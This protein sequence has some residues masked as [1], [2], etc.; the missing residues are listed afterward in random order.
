MPE[1]RPQNACDG[2]QNA[3][4]QPRS[5]QTAQKEMAV[6]FRALLLPRLL[7]GFCHKRVKWPNDHKVSHAG[8][9]MSTAKADWQRHWAM[10][11]GQA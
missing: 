9:M 11:P 10:A 2:H 7:L 4:R 8:A 5:E 1:H 6:T 3:K